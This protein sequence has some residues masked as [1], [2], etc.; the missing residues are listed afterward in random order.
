MLAKSTAT[1]VAF[2]T[3]VALATMVALAKAQEATVECEASQYLD[4]ETEKCVDY[5]SPDEKMLADLGTPLNSGNTAWMLISSAL[6]FFMTPGVAFFYAGLAGEHMASNTIMMSYVSIAVVSMQFLIW[7]YSVSFN[8]DITGSL[9]FNGVGESP[10]GVYGIAVPHAVW[11]LFQTQFA[12]ITPALISGGIVGRMKFGSYIIFIL[13]WT[14]VVYNPLARWMWSYKLSDSYELEAMGWEAKFGSLDFAGGTVIHV[15]SGFAALVAALIVGKRYNH[16]EEVKPHNV[17]LVMI[18][19]TL[20]WFGWF[21]FNAGSAVAADGIAAIAAV[22]THMAASAGFIS[23]VALE[24]ALDGKVDAC[25]S[26]SGAVAGLVAITPACG[27]VPIWS[28]PFFGI[29]G[30]ITAIVAIK[31][32]NKLRYDDTLDCFAIHGCGGFM[33]GILTGIFASSE[34]NAV[35]VHEG[36]FYGGWE[37]IYHQIVANAFAAVYSSVWTVVILFALKFTIGIRVAEEKEAAG[38]D[39][40]YHGGAAYANNSSH[41]GTIMQPANSPGGNFKNLMSPTNDNPES[42]SKV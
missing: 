27:Y 6:V 8:Q 38:M 4:A 22:N 28:S 5:T 30:S 9:M 31:I 16:H 37:Q 35:V 11:A 36:V 33:G 17:P 12:T 42:T 23:W 10:S 15:S 29:V 1:K 20:L 3:V 40:S 21:G 25:G 34:V 2:A 13:I 18:G 7:G 24:Y 32:K 14:T 41:A 39:V 19:A 26:A